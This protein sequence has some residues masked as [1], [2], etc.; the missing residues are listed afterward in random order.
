MT[1]RL[2]ATIV[3]SLTLAVSGA[4]PASAM[5]PDYASQYYLNSVCPQ[6]PAFNG[7]IRALFRG[8]TTLRPSQVHG[9]RLR[10]TRRA[11]LRLQRTDFNAASH[12]SNTPSDWPSTDSAAATHKVAIAMLRERLIIVELR[13]RSRRSFARYW[14]RM[15]LPQD[16]RIDTFWRLANTSLG[17]QPN[18]ALGC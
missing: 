17:I 1:Q 15:F 6:I 7:V 9:E 12:L 16:H 13:T 11:L 5:T 14:N 4:A 18:G 8:K 3:L 2:L 10:Q